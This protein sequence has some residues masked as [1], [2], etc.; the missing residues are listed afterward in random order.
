MLPKKERLTT[1]L[2]D[3][4]MVKGVLV[5]GQYFTIKYIK[6]SEPFSRFA[7]AVA[8]KNLKK[9]VERNRLRRRV[10]HS[11]SAD[12]VKVPIMAIV[13]PKKGT[14][15]LTTQVIQQEIK[16]MLEKCV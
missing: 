1:T 13:L 2:F 6:S 5:H 8:K 12:A 16:K 7:V 9:A 14:E 11:I 4:I 3:Q 10:Y 15:T